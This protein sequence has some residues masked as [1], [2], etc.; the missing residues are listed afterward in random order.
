MM[1]IDAYFKQA[2][3]FSKSLTI[4]FKDVA[5]AMNAGVLVNGGTISRNP[6][7]WKYYMNMAGE[8]HSSN[9]DVLVI[10]KETGE[11]VVLTKEILDNN[12]YTRQELQKLDAY[13][14]DLIDNYPE[15]EVFI[16]GCLWP[17]DKETAIAAEDGTILAYDTSYPASNEY[18]LIRELQTYIYSFLQRWHVAAYT[19]T[20]ELYLSSMLAVLYST[21]PSRIINSKLDKIQT[22][23][24]DAFHLEHYFRSNLNLY[25]DLT[26]LKPQ[27]QFWLYN[28]FEYIKRNIGKHGTFTKLIEKVFQ[29]NELGIGEYI[30]KQPDNVLNE[31]A[32]LTE[33]VF[34]KSEALTM[35]KSL[36]KSYKMSE[37]QEKS[38]EKAV[39]LEIDSVATISEDDLS[40]KNTY[41][42]DEVNTAIQNKYLDNQKTKMLDIG[43]GI[44]YKRY[45]F[46]LFRVVLDHWVYLCK[47]NQRDPEQPGLAIFK[48]PTI[49]FTD[50][51]T[52]K[53][54]AISPRVGLLML[55]KLMLIVTGQT[56]QKIQDLYYTMVLP[57][58][59]TEI[60]KVFNKMY[61]DGYISYYIEDFKKNIPAHIPYFSQKEVVQ[62]YL[63]NVVNFY[64]YVWMQDANSESIATSFLIKQLFGYSLQQGKYTITTEPKT[65]DQLLQDEGIVYKLEDD[66]DI[67][68]SIEDLILAFTGVHVDEY[69]YIKQMLEHTKSLL[70]KVT[71]YTVQI[72]T[73]SKNEKSTPAFYNNME[74]FKVR[75]GLINV[76]GSEFAPLEKEYVNIIAKGLN[77]ID[78]ATL[79]YINDVP[80]QSAFCRQ[81]I[82]GQAEIYKGPLVYTHPVLQI[83]MAMPFVM[84]TKNCPHEDHFLTDVKG[85]WSPNED[86]TGKNMGAGNNTYE[87]KLFSHLENSVPTSLTVDKATQ[88]VIGTMEIDPIT[89]EFID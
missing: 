44:L 71:S 36:N 47:Q 1:L 48:E 33:S 69:Y 76:T 3:S 73:D 52:S 20:D 81:T 51:N 84:D 14:D 27:T 46:D 13:Y 85:I 67:R 37:D 12:P 49:D 17:I 11:E 34:N 64:S 38:I 31:D 18:N 55:V 72:V 10:L 39:L 28:N 8:K 59:T 88:D 22:N 82:K 75:N 7:E 45:G 26:I 77:F 80:M 23:E 60:D 40:S 78:E 63:N 9:K 16:R 42:V 87:G 68:K 35:T 6:R 32:K 29:E 15:E 50:P 61:D 21:L 70:G 54:Y 25:D 2:I 41:L 43:V 30:I 4:K 79:I 5:I 86:F 65:I 83:D 58:S 74:A 89:I 24:A 19:I 53:S 66:A 57:K 62:D 56:D